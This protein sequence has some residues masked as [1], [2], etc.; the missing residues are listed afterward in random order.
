[1]Q[2]KYTRVPRWAL[3]LYTDLCPV[4]VSALPRKVNTAGSQP[5]VTKGFQRRGQIDLIDFQSLP[6]GDYKFLLNYQDHGIKLFHCMPLTVRRPRTCNRLW[7]AHN[8]LCHVHNRL[9]HAHN[10]LWSAHNG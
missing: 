10:W 7:H 3:E 9:W 8:R 2:D 6:D 1:M 5:I 4:C